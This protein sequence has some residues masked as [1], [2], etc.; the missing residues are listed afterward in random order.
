MDEPR[1]C[2]ASGEHGVI[3][4]LGAYAPTLVISRVKKFHQAII[5]TM[6]ASLIR[7]AR[8]LPAEEEPACR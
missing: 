4:R 8:R 2:A 5:G 7:Q 3:L 6:T 1:N